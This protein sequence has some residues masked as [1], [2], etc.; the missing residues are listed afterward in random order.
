MKIPDSEA[1]LGTE[2]VW[3]K[4]KGFQISEARMGRADMLGRKAPG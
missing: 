4:K 2:D 1:A 3:T